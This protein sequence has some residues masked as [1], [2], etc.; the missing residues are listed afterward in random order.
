M[1]KITLRAFPRKNYFI[2]PFGV[3]SYIFI[4]ILG[5]FAYHS[6]PFWSIFTILIFLSTLLL[7]LFYGYP[8]V[9]S[10][11]LKV[12]VGDDGI[13]IKHSN[14]QSTVIPFVDIE[15]VSYQAILP[16]L[17]PIP[18]VDSYLVIKLKDSKVSQYKF[19]SIKHEKV[20]LKLK[21]DFNEYLG[22][23]SSDIYIQLKTT[24]DKDAKILDTLLDK[25]GK[26]RS[27]MLSPLMKTKDGKKYD[28][29]KDKYFGRD[30][31]K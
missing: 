5:V 15:W 17:K 9:K 31:D 12:E 7:I 1:E 28:E 13:V 25:T 27:E 29:I 20:F 30:K 10:R 6:D 4:I 26:K 16:Y 3:L 24:S 22:D 18:Q 23:K 11:H 2:L 19:L 8:V 14:K 21:K